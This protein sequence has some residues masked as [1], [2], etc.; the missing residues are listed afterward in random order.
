MVKGECNCGEVSFE[1]AAEISDVYVCHCSICRR[2]TGAGGIAVTVVSKKAFSW[3]GGENAIKMWAKPGHDWQTSF[4]KH[5]GSSLPGSNDD[6]RMYVPVGLIT[7]GGDDLKVAHH[8]WVNSKASWE[9]I[10]DEGK[11]HPEE[12]TSKTPN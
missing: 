10:G 4:C 1:I 5:C 9:V 7:Q 11:Q 12:F 8:I 3:Q 2:A 6:E